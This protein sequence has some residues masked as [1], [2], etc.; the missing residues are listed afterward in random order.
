MIWHS[1]FL[2]LF[3][4]FSKYCLHWIAT[5]FTRFG[6][7]PTTVLN[8]L[9]LPFAHFS[10]PILPMICKFGLLIVSHRSQMMFMLF[11]FNFVIEYSNSLSLSSSSNTNFHLILLV[12]FPT[13]SFIGIFI[14][15]FSTFL[16]YF[17]LYLIPLSYS[18]LTSS[19]H[20]AVCS[21]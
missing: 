18:V 7:F 15:K 20:P 11:Y 4:W 12:R 3:I 1:I 10:C 14:S 21:D 5:S 13:I 17:Y 9:S 6:N 19:F 8:T 16:Q 2:I